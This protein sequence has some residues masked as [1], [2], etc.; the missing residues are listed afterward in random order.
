M[1]CDAD[2][3]NL[4]YGFKEVVTQTSWTASDGIYSDANC[5]ILSPNQGGSSRINNSM[6][7]VVGKASSTVPGAYEIQLIF[8][9][10]TY[11][12]IFK[13]EGNKLYKGDTDTAGNGSSASSRP[14]QLSSKFSTK[15]N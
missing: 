15:V 14:T 8:Q 3:L 10:Q 7:Y 1:K 2:G 11:Y 6:Q 12:G 5:T 9:G 4:W 13:I